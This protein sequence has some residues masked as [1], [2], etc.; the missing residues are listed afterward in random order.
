M[1]RIKT[2]NR[3]FFLKD[4]IDSWQ[5]LTKLAAFTFWS[6]ASSNMADWNETNFSVRELI[7]CVPFCVGERRGCLCVFL[8][9]WLVYW[10]LRNFVPVCTYYICVVFECIFSILETYVYPPEFRIGSFHSILSIMGIVRIFL[11]ICPRFSHPWLLYISASSEAARDVIDATD[12]R[13][14]LDA[15]TKPHTSYPASHGVELNHPHWKSTDLYYH[16]LLIKSEDFQTTN[17]Y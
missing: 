15:I 1:G 5:K 6:I 12:A 8:F 17:E 14:R 13:T 10:I 9:D 2:F 16:F 4:C 3:G 11:L 7:Y